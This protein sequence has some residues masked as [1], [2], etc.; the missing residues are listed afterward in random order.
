MPYHTPGLSLTQ[1][2]GDPQF[3][4][5]VRAGLKLGGTLARKVAAKLIRPS[6]AVARTVAG[7]AAAAGAV[8]LARR[9][10]PG[11]RGGIPLPFGRRFR[12]GRIFPG[13]RPAFTAEQRP[14]GFHWSESA[15]DWVK[16]RRM[17]VT[18]SRA[19]RRAIRRARGFAKL[20]KKVLTFVAAKAPA[21][22][23]KFKA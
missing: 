12:P 8:A 9:A 11:P 23:P 3:G 1:W 7:G 18:N 17:N 20:A 5:L 14:A 4:L 21:G 13:G 19:L 10:A 15:G 22:R 2:R 16:N 6:T